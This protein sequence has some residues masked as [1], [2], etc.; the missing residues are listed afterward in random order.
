MALG[1]CSIALGLFRLE[2]RR[3]L[4]LDQENRAALK[5]DENVRF[6][7]GIVAKVLM[8]GMPDFLDRLPG[9]PDPVRERLKK[10]DAE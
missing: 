1:A 7:P 2:A 10:A 4:V 3:E 5:P 8:N 9:N 6:S